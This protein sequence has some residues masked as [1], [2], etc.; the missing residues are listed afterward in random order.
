MWENYRSCLAK[1]NRK[2]MHIEG[3]NLGYLLSATARTWIC[4][5]CI[6][7]NRKPILDCS[8]LPTY[9]RWYGFILESLLR[10]LSPWKDSRERINSQGWSYQWERHTLSHGS[11]GTTLTVAL[12]KNHFEVYLTQKF[13]VGRKRF[14]TQRPRKIDCSK[15]VS[16]ARYIEHAR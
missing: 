10:S 8:S 11:W 16:A 12:E 3:K 14:F 13:G 15:R 1:D 9:F 4:W 2:R 5:R 6:H 7:C